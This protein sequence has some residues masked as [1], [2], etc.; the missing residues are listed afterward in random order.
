[1]LTLADRFRCFAYLFELRD[2]VDI[3][4]WDIIENEGISKERR[5]DLEG[6]IPEDYLDFYSVFDGLTF[7]YELPGLE[8]D[9]AEHGIVL[10]QL[11]PAV[12]T[13]QEG[14]WWE[15]FGHES[16]D[17]KYSLNILP[18][19]LPNNQWQVQFLQTEGTEKREA[20]VAFHGPSP[21]ETRWWDTFEDYMTDGARHGFYWFW[22]QG[23]GIGGV[24]TLEY[25]LENSVDASMSDDELAGLLVAQGD[26]LNDELPVDVTEEVADALVDWLADRVVLLIPEG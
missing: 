5:R 23:G 17:F 11:D 7:R 2:D 18:A 26:K 25:L 19:D 8:G 15:S 22:E 9:H 14:K 3:T 12:P 24:D 1:M 4:G 16:V 10:E 21:G 13:G 6:T 20:K